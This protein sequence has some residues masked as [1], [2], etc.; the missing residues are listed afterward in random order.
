[1]DRTNSFMSFV[2]TFPWMLIHTFFND[3]NLRDS[4]LLEKSYIQI[5]NVNFQ[6]LMIETYWITWSKC[7]S[8]LISRK[9]IFVNIFFQKYDEVIYIS[10]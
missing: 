10:D 4:G 6:S 5:L 2:Q 3:V 8:S 1:M 9:M 7:F